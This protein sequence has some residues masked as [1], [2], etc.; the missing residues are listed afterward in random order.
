MKYTPIIG[1]K[2]NNLSFICRTYVAAKEATYDTLLEAK[3]IYATCVFEGKSNP[4]SYQQL[5]F[6]EAKVAIYHN[7]HLVT[8]E[9]TSVYGGNYHI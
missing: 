3:L 7:V 5:L 6:L 1:G 8:L 9:A 4:F 2:S